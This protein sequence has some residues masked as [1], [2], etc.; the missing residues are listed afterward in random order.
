MLDRH[1][2]RCYF[3]SGNEGGCAEM[4]IRVLRYFLAVAREGTIV[5]AAKFLH[6]TQPTLS[7]QLQDLEE[8]LGQRLFL[9]SN[10]SITLT[11]EGHFLRKRAEEVLEIVSRTESDFSLMGESVGGSVHIGGGESRAMRLI[12]ETIR[13]LR[14]EYPDFRYNLYSGNAED[15]ME[16]LDKGILDFGILI[17]PVDISKYDSLPLPLRDVWGVVMRKDSPLAEKKSVTLSDLL[18]LPLLC[19]RISIR[20]SSVKNACAG[21]FGKQFEKLNIVATYNLIYNAALMVESGIGYALALDGL[22]DTLGNPALCFRP[23]EPGLESG[24]DIVWKKYQVFSRAAE[25]FL[26]RIRDRFPEIG[27]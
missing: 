22:V 14:G 12:A 16:R 2:M 3:S 20:Q 27:A 13:G 4:E 7:R 24:L 10:R 8:E 6:V 5:R 25:I 19:S 17:Q 23:L 9:R 26:E 11:P 21:W 15:V 1:G 18:P